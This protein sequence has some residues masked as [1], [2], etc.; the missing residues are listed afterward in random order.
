MSPGAAIVNRKLSILQPL[1]RPPSTTRSCFCHGRL[2]NVSD[3][4]TQLPEPPVIEAV[5][6]EAIVAFRPSVHVN[7]S[8]PA[9]STNDPSAVTALPGA[10]DV[11]VA[12]AGAAATHDTASAQSAPSVPFFILNPLL[13]VGGPK[14]SHSDREPSAARSE[15]AAQTVTTPRSVSVPVTLG[16][17]MHAPL[18]T[19]LS[20]SRTLSLIVIVRTVSLPLLVHVPE[21]AP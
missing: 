19:A 17:A 5:V 2:S 15:M 3:A 11:I 7:D 4:L 9:C 8:K 10:G 14:P 20:S 21:S 18:D 6:P 16:L 12:A 1:V 13:E